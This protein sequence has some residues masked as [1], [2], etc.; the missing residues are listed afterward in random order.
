MPTIPKDRLDKYRVLKR[1]FAEDKFINLQPIQRGGVLTPEAREA[2]VEF[3]DGYSV[4]D[5]CPPKSARLDKI[6]KP[7][8]A[9]FMGD[10]AEFLGLDVARVVT[11]CREA[12]FIAFTMLG[13][14]GDYI[15]LDSLAHYSTYTAVELARMKVKEVPH[16]EHPEFRLDL[17]AYA[18][19][20][21]EVK[22]ET[23]KLPAAVLLTHVD[24]LYGNLNDPVAVGKIAKQYGVPFILNAAYTGGTMDLDGKKLGADVITSSGHKSWAAGA[25][26]GILAA[27]GE[28]GEKLFARSQIVG[29]WSKR[30]FGLKEYALLGCTVMGAPLMTLIASFPHVVERVQ[31]WPQEVANIRHLV[32]QLERIEGTRQI[33]VRPKDHTLTH[34]ESDGFFRA[35]ETHKRK[36]FFLYD[37]LRK[38]NIVGIQPGLTKHF[39]LNTYGLPREK[40][41]AVARAFIEIAEGLKLEVS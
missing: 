2:A 33:G 36:G 32:E 13:N 7:P 17:D 9:S 6:E 35:S 26:T 10:L 27:T 28:V 39:K 16:G 31:R 11:R 19:K 8:I 18:A 5:W 25:P 1:D 30:K 24:Y 37:E 41:E 21:E 4:C 14:P 23:G 20:I 3:A 12:Q 22:K 38:R 15:V 29:D 40:V 34:M